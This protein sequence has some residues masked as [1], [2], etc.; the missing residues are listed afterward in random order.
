[1]RHLGLSYGACQS[2]AV[3]RDDANLVAF[4]GAAVMPNTAVIFIRFFAVVE[5][6][7]TFTKTCFHFVGF[8][9]GVS[10]VI[11]FTVF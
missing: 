6:R 8:S 9:G 2:D 1:M 4:L 3:E 11:V 10:W 7:L 5:F